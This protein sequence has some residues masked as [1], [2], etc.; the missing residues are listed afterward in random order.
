MLSLI[1][2]IRLERGAYHV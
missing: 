1:G 2:D